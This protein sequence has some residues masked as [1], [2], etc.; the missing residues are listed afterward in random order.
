MGVPKFYGLWLSRQ[1]FAREIS[2]RNIPAD[3]SVIL[4]DMNSYIYKT[5]NIVYLLGD[6]INWLDPYVQA[7]SRW[8]NES[9]QETLEAEH[10]AAIGNELN[11][12]LNN[13]SLSV[14]RKGQNVHSANV[15][16][17]ALDAFVLAVD[18]VAPQA[19]MMQ[20]RQRRYIHAKE[21]KQTHNKFVNAAITPGTEFMQKLNAY[22]HT[23]IQLNRKTLGKKVIYS[24]HLVPGEAEHKI[25]NY[26]RNGDIKTEG[27]TLI[28]GMDTDLIMLS[29]L[30][31]HRRLYLW[32]EDINLVLN[33]DRLRD[34][35][36]TLMG[37]EKGYRD[38]VFIMFFLGNDFLPSQ[39]GL[40]DYETSINKLIEAYKE[41]NLSLINDDGIIWENVL[42]YLDKLKKI[43]PSLM[44]H[45]TQRVFKFNSPIYEY[46]NKIIQISIPKQ[47]GELQSKIERKKI[48][49]WDRFRSAWYSYA[50]SPRGDMNL[51]NS[52]LKENLLKVSPTRIAEMANQYLI[53]LNWVYSYYTKGL[54]GIN[55][56]WFYSYYKT[57]L[58]FD[59]FHVL[60][61]ILELKLTVTGWENIGLPLLSSIHQLLTV[62]PPKYIHLI[63][64]EV[65]GLMS[66]D[67]PIADYYPIDYFIERMGINEEWRGYALLP[68]VNPNRII[69]A[70]NDFTTFSPNSAAKYLPENDVISE[71]SDDAFQAVCL[72]TN[73]QT[74]LNQNRRERTDD[75]GKKRGY[76]GFKYRGRGFRESEFRRGSGFSD[77]GSNFRGRRFDFRGSNF[78]GNYRRSDENT[79]SFPRQ[80]TLAPP[81]GLILPNQ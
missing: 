50:L 15:V 42:L 6:N 57:P 46:A 19:K 66:S 24:S 35:I 39:P 30:S 80:T 3:V 22:L 11:K 49:E 40:D 44:E 47:P 38:F 63:P 34:E 77:R 69:Q 17:R 12:L 78:R 25:M 18:G 28:H 48:F 4:I 54:S 10:F 62:I 55:N 74:F 23:W 5:A 27:A 68:F 61:E 8:I 43:E 41:N 16:G 70:V 29:L 60:H 71:M 7:R 45:E 32:R 36:T 58:F 31:T 56:R 73:A 75:R 76:R 26:L 53:G 2:D 21:N 67:S 81:P 9:S 65:K 33:I 14:S 13:V 20:Q 1:P 64:E 59:L 52:V 79:L 51:I 72:Q 37:R